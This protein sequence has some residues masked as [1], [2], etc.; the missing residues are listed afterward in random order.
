MQCFCPDCFA[1]AA[2]GAMT[3]PV[4]GPELE[5]DRRGY[6]DKLLRALHHPIPDH[7]I[8]AARV[9]GE[10]RSERAIP[11]LAG[12][13]SQNPDYYLARE[14]LAALLKIGSPK[15]LHVLEEAGH[16]RSRLIRDFARELL[17]STATGEERR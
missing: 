5:S 4:C 3:C 2:P 16:G 12:L 15:S 1:E 9:L 10:H 17:S 14:V 6:E 8:M 7:Q 13:L 11:E